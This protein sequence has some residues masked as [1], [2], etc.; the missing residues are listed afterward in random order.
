MRSKTAKTYRILTY[1]FILT[2]MIAGFIIWKYVPDIIKN[3]PEIHVGNGAYGSKNGML[4]L[5]PIPLFALC[6]TRQKQEPEFHGDDEA[7]RT[8]VQDASDKSQWLCGMITALALSLLV[9][10]SMI[11]G[12]SL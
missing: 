12:L 5:L 2:G 11:M 3:Y 4:L 7:Y 10:V 1:A 6:F 9:I 8:K